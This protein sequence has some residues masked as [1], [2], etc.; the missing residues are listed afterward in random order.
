VDAQHIRALDISTIEQAEAVSFDH[1]SHH[2]HTL[3][4]V[5]LSGRFV[6][7]M[8]PEQARFEAAAASGEVLQMTFVIRDVE[9]SGEFTVSKAGEE[10]KLDP[11]LPPRPKGTR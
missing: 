1:L 8:S 11:V 6:E 4:P 7:A 10:Y 5:V 3:G 9:H 2:L